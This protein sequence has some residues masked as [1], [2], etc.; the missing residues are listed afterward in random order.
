MLALVASMNDTNGTMF[1]TLM[2]QFGRPK[3][4]AAYG[5]MSIE[6]GP[7][8]TMLTLGAAGLAAFPWQAMLGAVLPLIAG[9]VLGNVDRA[10]RDWLSPVCGG[11]I[12]LIAFALGSTID[13]GAVWKAGVLGLGLGVFVFLWTGLFLHAVDCLT[14]GTGV[15]GV[16]AATTAGS[17]IVVPSIVAEVNPAYQE[18]AASATVLVAASVVVT[19]ILAPLGTALVAE[20][21]AKRLDEGDESLRP[22]P[23]DVGKTQVAEEG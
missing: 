9:A 6:S 13:L 23:T 21:V 17:A 18:A 19:A 12:P 15:A 5:V 1:V 10:M 11:L 3:D 14:H 20:R 16:A 8:F 22:E 4:A 2:H 7:F